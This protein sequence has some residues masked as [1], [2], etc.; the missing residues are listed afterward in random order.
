M[1]NTRVLISGA[2]IAGPALAFWLQRYGFEVTIVEKASGIRAGGQAV[3]FKGPIHETVLTKMGIL[4]AVKAASVPNA[5]GILVNARGRK[6]GTIPGSFAGGEINVPRGDLANILYRLTADTCEYLFDNSIITLTDTGNEV[7]VSFTNHPPRTFDIVVGADGIHSNVR[8]LAFGH[9]SD[10]VSHLGYYYVL[11]KIDAGDD[12]MMYNEPGIMA[13]LGGS[14]APAFFVFA[15]PLLPAARDNTEVQKQQVTDALKNGSWRIPEL[16]AQFPTAGEFYMDSISRVTT[17]HYSKGRVVLLGDSAYGNALGGFGTGLSVVGAYVL[18]G[19]LAR[20]DGD[21]TTA[22]TQYETKYR[23]YAS[24]S[25]KVNAGRLL[26]PATKPGIF[27]RNR[28]FSALSLFGPLMK[29]IDKP[30]SNL[31]LENYDGEITATTP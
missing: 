10:Y 28:L 20:A 6:V 1:N 4:D 3:D 15:S 14:K 8:K 29:I 19:E 23:G 2:S 12:D 31:T 30:A 26:A 7:E 16:L 27:L 13:A 21:H 11:A 9:E 24:V 22:F 5:D 17:E 18:A 25:Q